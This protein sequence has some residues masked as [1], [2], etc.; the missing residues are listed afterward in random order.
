MKNLLLGPPRY[1]HYIQNF[2]E[3]LQTLGYSEHT[4]KIWPNVLREFLHYLES[5]GITEL[6][7]LREAHT[8][9][10]IDYIKVRKNKRKEGAL[11]ISYINRHIDLLYKFRDYMKQTGGIQIPVMISRSREERKTDQTILKVDEIKK[12]YQVTDETPLGIRDR[13]MLAVYYGGAL[14]KSEGVNLDQSD[15]LFDRKLLHIRK[16]KNNYERYVPITTANLKSIEQYVYNARPLLLEEGTKES[17]LFIS[18]RGTRAHNHTLYLR[19]KQLGQKAGITKE[20]GLHTLRHSIATHLL[21]NGME[22]ENIALFLGHRSLDS[23]QIYTH[24]INEQ[25]Q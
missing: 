25:K 2:K 11:S 17:A 1:D 15:V 18:E 10:Y 13:A 16:T 23:T 7:N 5:V 9:N 20:I 24:I 4:V 21:Q 8:G 19:L 22:L 14:R 3:W 12:L 6:A